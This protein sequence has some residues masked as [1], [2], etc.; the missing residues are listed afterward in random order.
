MTPVALAPVLATGAGPVA[1]GSEGGFHAPDVTLFDFGPVF[2][3]GGL[4]VTKP[5]LLAIIGAAIVIAFFYF[6]TVNAR[7]VP[8]RWQ[9]VAEVGYLFVR[10]EVARSIIGKRGDKWVPLLVSM[11]F[12]VWMLNL[13]SVIPLAQ[14]PVTSKIAYPAILAIGVWL[15]FV[16]LGIVKQGPIGYFKNMMFPPGIPKFV[17][18]ILA[19]L[20]FVSTIFVRPFT[21]AVRLFA[22]MFAGHVIVTF[23][24]LVAWY[25]IVEAPGPGVVIGVVGFLMTIVMTAFEM[26]IQALQAFIFTL[27]TAV[28]IQSSIEA[29][30]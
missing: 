27:L 23:F 18:V 1:S 26:F 4:D 5:M 3:I 8:T 14:V 25:F 28:Y 22:N 21:L 20:E 10:D 16:I 7:L 30:H 17:Y 29:A 6:S 9:S 12:F 19:P 24:A 13:F 2:T 15:L 11:F